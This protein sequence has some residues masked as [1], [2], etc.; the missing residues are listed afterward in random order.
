M[1]FS[2]RTIIAAFAAASISRNGSALSGAPCTF[3]SDA[4]RRDSVWEARFAPQNEL[5]RSLPPVRASGNVHSTSGTSSVSA[6]AV[7][8]AASVNVTWTT[9]SRSMSEA[10]SVAN[11]ASAASA[12]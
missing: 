6:I 8:T 11:A 10:F 2:W 5:R 7:T 1:T 3:S 12:S 9:S 4:P